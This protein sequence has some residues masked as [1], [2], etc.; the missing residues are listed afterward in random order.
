MMFSPA[1]QLAELVR[2]LESR[3]HVFAVDPEPVTEILRDDPAPW[4]Q[5]LLKRAALIDADGRLAAMLARTQS[6]L[7][8]SVRMAC[9]VLMIMGFS[10]TAALMAAP[11]LNFFYV[12][13]SV[14]GVNTLMML[15][16]LATLLRP[17]FKNG[18]PVWLPL[19]W[20]GQNQ[21]HTVRSALAQ[22]Y[23][24]AAATPAMRWYGGMV[25]HRLW[26]CSLAGMW[27]AMWLMLLVRQYAFSWESTLLDNHTLAAWVG[28]LA[29]LPQQLGFAVPDAATIAASRDAADSS[30]AR[31]WAGFLLG[32]VLCY[33]LLPRL[34]LWLLCAWQWRRRQQELPLSLPYYRHIIQRWQQQV[35]DA[36]TVAEA[37]A[38]AAAPIRLSDA[39]KQAALLDAPWP[40][41]QWHRHVLGQQWQDGGVI[42]HR[43]ALRRLLDE[44]QQH[45]AQLLIGV[46][47]QVVPDRGLLRQ[48]G[49][50]ADAAQ[51]GVVVQLLAQDTA[52][53]AVIRQWQQALDERAIA[54]LPPAAWAQQ[55]HRSAL[56]EHSA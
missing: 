53:S 6:V 26:L 20:R 18:S 44:L 31:L 12:L 35:V 7:A 42:D 2:L 17:P 45:P 4:P 54:W 51:G 1:Q 37:P 39:P 52:D 49:A 41:A 34:G 40:D 36:D 24:E 11:Q 21:E 38:R 9:A 10:A 28:A 14:L 19:L 23:T 27:L 55:Q 32:S 25:S 33:G 56:T 47:A 15:L 29:W 13:L 22:L 46:R 43:D 16:W 48:I 8:W 50:L 5:R 30:Q 3:G